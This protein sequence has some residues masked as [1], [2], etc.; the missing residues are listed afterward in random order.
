METIIGIKGKDFVMLAADSTHPH[1]IMVL[2]DDENKIHKISDS[3]LIAAI[4]DA[5]DTVQ[6]VEYISKNILLYKMRNGY[7]LSPKSA[8]YFTRKNLADY[9]RTRYAYQVWLLVAG[10]DKK[11]GPQLTFIDYLSNTLSVK[12]GAHGYGGMFCGSIFDKYHHDN[13]TQE[14]AYEIMRK[15]AREIQ[16]RLIIS[17][18]KFHV[19]IVDANG[20]KRLEDITTENLKD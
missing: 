3:L 4:G 6:F 13:L 5:G 15:C 1:S 20:V 16:K 17:Q 10:Y 9:L 8:A 12:H 18:P 11:E 14:E 19:Q 2:K 7:E